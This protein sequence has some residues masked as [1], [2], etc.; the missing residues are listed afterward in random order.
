MT[1]RSCTLGTKIC[2]GIIN[3]LISTARRNRFFRV[4][5]ARTP[6]TTT[7]T[8]MR[9]S[10]RSKRE[11]QRPGASLT[12]QAAD[13]ISASRPA[14]KMS[15]AM[16]YPN[17]LTRHPSPRSIP[18]HGSILPPDLFRGLLCVAG[19]LSGPVGPGARLGEGTRPGEGTENTSALLL[20]RGRSVP[21]IRPGR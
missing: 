9:K 10:V 12:R 6:P 17:T 16:A 14:G 11:A 4:F 7:T 18:S 21:G 2:R 13:G 8:T 1:F 15:T 5:D 3:R 20:P 19:S